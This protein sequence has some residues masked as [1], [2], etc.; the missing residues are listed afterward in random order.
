MTW[1]SKERK[2][3]IN[4]SYEQV[5]PIPEGLWDR[6]DSC[7]GIYFQKDYDKNLKVCPLCGAHSRISAVERLNQLFD[8]EYELMDQKLYST[9][10]LEFTDKKSYKERL[11]TAQ[12][13]T[14]ISDALISAHGKVG[15]RPTVI[16]AQE[17]SF[18]GG[19]MGS[20][21]G[22]RI[23]RAVE[24]AM[25]KNMPVIIVSCTG[26]ARMQEGILSLMQMAKTA[27][28]LG[29]F[30]NKGL[31]YIS[32]LANPSTAGCLASF[33]MLGDFILAEPKALI[34]FAG[35]RV[36]EQTI[37]KKLPEGFQRAEFLLE[38]GMVD[39]VVDRREL[40]EVIVRLFE[41]AMG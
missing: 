21:V 1:Y 9:D 16:C 10:P 26:G 23:T 29:R 7:K 15:E 31:P 14:G 13:K 11:S 36:I 24:F 3:K 20:V 34:G 28:V 22:E 27:A 19:S 37:R 18:M 8:G 12:K 33:G 41:Y 5:T 40:K 25:Q 4:T 35:P 38:H 30:K 2:A 39:R 32:V 17:F 6:C